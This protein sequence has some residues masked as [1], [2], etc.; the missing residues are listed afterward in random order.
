MYRS[1]RKEGLQWETTKQQNIVPI[2][3][4]LADVKEST[5]QKCYMWHIITML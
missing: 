4:L 5:Q 2:C 3:Q 1:K